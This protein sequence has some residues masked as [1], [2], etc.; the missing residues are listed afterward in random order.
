MTLPLTTF[1]VIISPLKTLLGKEAGDK[2]TGM[3]HVH[4]Q[5][6]IT[7]IKY[8]GTKEPRLHELK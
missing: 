7:G 1:H 2:G 5:V 8:T 4:T 6:L 3:T